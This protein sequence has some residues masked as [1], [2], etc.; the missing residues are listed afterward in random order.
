MHNGQIFVCAKNARYVRIAHS[1]RF[2]WGRIEKPLTNFIEGEIKSL[3]LV[4]AGV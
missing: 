1:G 2:K 3:F 4:P